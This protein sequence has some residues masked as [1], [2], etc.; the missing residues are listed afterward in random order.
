MYKKFI[1]IILISICG[2]VNAQEFEPLELVQKVFT[3][4]DFAKKTNG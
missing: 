2:I 3:D 1:T 4:K